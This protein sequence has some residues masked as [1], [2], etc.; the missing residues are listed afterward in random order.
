MI[1]DSRARARFVNIRP[2]P[3]VVEGRDAPGQ[4]F[5]FQGRVGDTGSKRT[6]GR[7]AALAR[8]RGAKFHQSP[9]AVWFASPPAYDPIALHQCRPCL[10][11]RSSGQF[12]ER[13]NEGPPYLRC[14]A[15][16]ST[17]LRRLL[18]DLAG[19]MPWHHR[20][21]GL[22]LG[23]D[24]RA[25][26]VWL[27]VSMSSKP[28]E[29]AGPGLYAPYIGMTSLRSRGPVPRSVPMPTPSLCGPKHCGG[30]LQI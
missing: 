12:Q 7:T 21:C 15:F 25:E 27:T 1:G 5:A 29:R 23:I 6:A 13:R 11:D 17:S 30:Q 22:D 4:P 20:N 10:L 8:R 16:W 14:S 19:A 28:R 26:R 18:R 9:T 3:A 2:P 24:F